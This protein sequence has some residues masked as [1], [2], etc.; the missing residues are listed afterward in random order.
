MSASGARVVPANVEVSDRILIRAWRRVRQYLDGL[1][2]VRGTLTIIPY[3]A[4]FGVTEVH[5]LDWRRVV[6]SWFIV[7]RTSTEVLVQVSSYVAIQFP[8]GECTLCTF[9]IMLCFKG[10]VQ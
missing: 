10:I 4:I 6:N 3:D 2:E 8:I 9:K 5:L 1:G 7:G